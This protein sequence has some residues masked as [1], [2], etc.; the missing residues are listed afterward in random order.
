MDKTS[1]LPFYMLSQKTSQQALFTTSVMNA[2]GPDPRMDQEQK[3]FLHP[4]LLSSC[5][6]SCHLLTL[7]SLWRHSEPLA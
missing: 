3:M 5:A 2:T 6:F 4:I 1:T 7:S